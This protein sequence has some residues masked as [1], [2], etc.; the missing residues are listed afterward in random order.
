MATAQ[1][2]R[3]ARTLAV[4]ALILAL[5]VVVVTP[6]ARTG[7]VAAPG[8]R[9]LRRAKFPYLAANVTDQQTKLPILLPFTIKLVQGV[10][11][12][13]VGMTLKGTAQIVNPAGVTT[14]DFRDEVDTANFYAGLLGLLGIRSLAL[15][16]HEGGIQGAPPPVLDPS[17]CNNFTGA[18][19]PIVAGLNP[20]YGV[21]VSG[22]THQWYTCSLPNAGGTS[23]VTSAGSFGRLVTDFSMTF[24]KKTRKFVSA[25]AHNVIA[26]NGI[27]NVD[28]TFKK[29]PDGSFVR[30]PAKVDAD[31]KVIAD[32]YRSQV[33]ALANK[34]VGSITSDITNIIPVGSS[35]ETA[36]GD[37][38][39]DAQLAYTQSASAQ[40][41]FMNPG[42]IRTSLTFNA[43]VGGEQPGQVTFGE[44][45]AVQPFNNLVVTQTLTGA[46]VKDTLEQQFPNT[47]TPLQS[48]TRI[49]QISKGF[50][51]TPN[52]AA[53]AGSRISNLALNGTPIDPAATYRVTTNDFLANGGDGFTTLTGGTDRVSA[54]AFDVDA[55][56]AYLGANSP[57]APPPLNRITKVG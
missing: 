23:V 20:N 34:V 29:N 1:W 56:V 57:V 31:A 39:A 33:A 11:V 40:I 47:Q 14:V 46:Q 12:G 41:A 35:G 51:Y 21:V 28:G 32:K 22:H 4:P 55:L 27:R 44:C 26:E 50:T 52:S 17:S 49:L 48:T 16:I 37:V 24:D 38:I 18:I 36:L 13:F 8:R 10:P 9:R 15:V 5:V 30:D 7:G 45:F 42:G 19:A 54:P 3:A 6:L 25:S 53:P 2:V 43:S